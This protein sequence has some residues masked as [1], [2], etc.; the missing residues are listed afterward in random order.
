MALGAEPAK[1]LRMILR[2][3]LL[4]VVVRI[5]IGLE[6]AFG[7]TRLMSSLLFEVSQTD[8]LTFTIPPLVLLTLAMLASFLPS[9]G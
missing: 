2:H 8:V 1:I 5:A 6:A 9:C 7:L 4:L 3:S